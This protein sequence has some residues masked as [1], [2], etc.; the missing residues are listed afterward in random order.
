MTVFST[1]K[2]IFDL[3]G[4]LVDTAADLHAA[5]NHVL[6]SLGRDS[7]SLAQVRHMTGYG[8]VKLIEL[9]LEATG[10]TADLD[11]ESLRQRFLRY[12]RANICEHSCVFPKGETMLEALINKG[13]Q[14]AVCT[15]KPIEMAQALLQSL[16][17][18]HYF[19]AITG[20]DSFSFKKPDPRHI[21]ETVSQLKGQGSAVM[22]G[23]ASPDILGAKAAHMPA[24]A[25]D[26]GY[27]DVPL[28]ELAPDHI[29]SCF[30]ALP[31]LLEYEP[32]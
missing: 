25:V 16:N 26:F 14:L 24:I 12:Y 6:Q 15:N 4:T 3:D 10:G 17:I 11:M 9:G 31:H 21:L 27:A 28:V 1:Q 23:D 20:G 8:A 29:I 13:F 22:V 2:V 18:D 30:S 7:V 19:G 32:A 5:T